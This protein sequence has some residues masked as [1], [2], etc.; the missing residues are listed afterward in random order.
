MKIT[1]Y[2]THCPRCNVLKQKL[3][4]SG[5][6]FEENNDVDLMVQRGFMSAPTLEVD[7]VVYD[8]MEAIEWIGEQ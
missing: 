1:L 2:S 8:F 7:N 5:I 6:T 3:I 4:Q